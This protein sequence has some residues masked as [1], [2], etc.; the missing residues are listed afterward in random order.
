MNR[1]YNAAR[2]ATQYGDL[3]FL[4]LADLL[5]VNGRRWRNSVTLTCGMSR[6]MRWYAGSVQMDA[7]AYNLAESLASGFWTRPSRGSDEPVVRGGEGYGPDPSLPRQPLDHD[8]LA[9]S[10]GQRHDGADAPGGLA[11]AGERPD[12]PRRVRL[13][14]QRHH[15][16]A[17]IEGAVH[18]ASGDGTL[19]LDPV[20]DRWGQARASM[21]AR[22][23][24]GMTRGRFS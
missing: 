18:L 17:A 5:E 21:M 1:Y 23:S 7:W 16:D 8:A 15:A 3:Q 22:V 12:G 24:G 14:D 19:A 4:A 20:E 6:V 13:G 10:L 9:M 2:P 11:R